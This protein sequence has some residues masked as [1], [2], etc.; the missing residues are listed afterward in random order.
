E[1]TQVE[2]VAGRSSATARGALHYAEEAGMQLE[3]KADLDLTELGHLA[4]FEWRGAASA[5][6]SVHGPYKDIKAE[7]QLSARDLAFWDYNPGTVQA[8]LSY[9]QK[10][11]H[12]TNITGQK[13]KTPYSGSADLDWSKEKN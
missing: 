7:A 3:G 13:G 12:F 4:K 5:A 2:V 1:L 9:Q 10:A 6:W 11:L 8:G